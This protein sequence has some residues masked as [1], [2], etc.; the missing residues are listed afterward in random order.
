MCFKQFDHCDTDTNMFVESFHNKL[1]IF[2]MEQIPNKRVD[3]LINILLTIEEGDY[4]RR[5]R[6]L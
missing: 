5:E 3:D 4:W 1:K 6:D 2:F